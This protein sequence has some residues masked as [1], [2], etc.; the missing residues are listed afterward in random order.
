M[1][2]FPSSFVDWGFFFG[3]SWRLFLHQSHKIYPRIHTLR[4]RQQST[5]LNVGALYTILRLCDQVWEVLSRVHDHDENERTEITLIRQ[6]MYVAPENGWK[7][8]FF[9]RELGMG[10]GRN[11]LFHASLL[12]DDDEFYG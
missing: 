3:M 1:L 12:V 4:E 11:T 2:P 8:C 6:E 7:C 10:F 5:A 9:E